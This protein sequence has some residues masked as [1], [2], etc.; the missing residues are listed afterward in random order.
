EEVEFT[1]GD[2]FSIEYPDDGHV[3]G[4]ESELYFQWDS[5]GFRQGV[6]IKFRL[7]IAAIIPGETINP[8]DAIEMG[9]SSVYYFDSEWS[10]L[11]VGVGWPYVEDGTSQS[12]NTFYSQLISQ[13]L[14][15]PLVCGYEYAW[16]M[17]AREII[18]EYND[19]GNY[20]IWGW[21]PDTEKSVVR[22]FTW[23]EIPSGLSSSPISGNDVL[24]TFTWN[25][26][27]CAEISQG[28]GYDI[29]ITFLD[30]S[31]FDNPIYND[32]SSSSSYNYYELAPGL[33]PGESYNWRVR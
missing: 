6:Q 16:R 20:G 10:E 2:H 26:M 24:P 17:E 12:I 31:E 1:L 7:I 33:I 4:G 29:Q 9:S 3:I 32:I 25:S 8:E 22:R 23:G 30:D 13:T 5:P 27:W 21:P 15:K 19:G 18:D 28:D 11:P 14:M